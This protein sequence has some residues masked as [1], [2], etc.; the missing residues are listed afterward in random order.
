MKPLQ[1]IIPIVNTTFHP[2]GSI[3]MESQIRL[4]RH[5]LGQGV[6]GL[7]FFGNAGEGYTLSEE[8]RTMILEAALVEVSG[9]V[10]VIVSTG[11][12]GTDQ[13]VRQSVRAAEIGADVLMI[14]PPYLL[15]PDANGVFGYFRAI[16]D[17]VSIPIMVQDAPLMTQVAMPVPL[18]ARM[19]KELE[20]VEY[21][22]VEAPPTAPKLGCACPTGGRAPSRPLAD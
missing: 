16:S 18:L 21:V 6:H 10:P 22:K 4:V 11:H 9:Q 3:D 20:H 17:A 2:D 19:G 12:T 7:A 13:A 1:G 8:E 15:K 5:L 14:L